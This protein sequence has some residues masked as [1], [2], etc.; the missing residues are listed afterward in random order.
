MIFLV[1]S[2]G[3]L[4]L[5]ERAVGLVGQV[6]PLLAQTALLYEPEQFDPS[7]DLRLRGSSGDWWRFY[8]R[9]GLDVSRSAV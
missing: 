2:R 6:E 9:Q 4:V 7:A 5:T 8:G 1:T 3:Q